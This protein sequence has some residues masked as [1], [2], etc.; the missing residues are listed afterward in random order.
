M[1]NSHTTQP[2]NI[3]YTNTQT[4]LYNIYPKNIQQTQHST[5]TSHIHQS[6]CT[7]VF[8]QEGPYDGDEG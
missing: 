3:R 6:L 2:Y 8:S 7:D 5:L 4:H 1:E